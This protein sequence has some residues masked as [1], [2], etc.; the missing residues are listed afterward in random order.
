M[1]QIHV[2]SI[3]RDIKYAVQIFYQK[4]TMKHVIRELTRNTDILNQCV[5][6]KKLVKWYI[7]SI[8]LCGAETWTLRKV[9]TWNIL[10]CYTGE[11]G[12]DQLHRSC[13]E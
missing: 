6:Y 1:A 10:K 3:Q 13:E 7:W 8:A 9:D 5:Y 12:L 2:P 11:D 4:Y